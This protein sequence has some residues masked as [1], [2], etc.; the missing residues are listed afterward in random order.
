MWLNKGNTMMYIDRNRCCGCGACSSK[1]PKIFALD[2]DGRMDFRKGIKDEEIR[3]KLKKSK[4][5]EKVCPFGA[6]H[7]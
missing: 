7:F 5:I 3:G 2:D 4:K 1:Y 6:I